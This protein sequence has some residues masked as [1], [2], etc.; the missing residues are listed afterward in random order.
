MHICEQRLRLQK[1]FWRQ[2]LQV[3][4]SVQLATV[5]PTQRSAQRDKYVKDQRAQEVRFATLSK[6][7][8][9]L[10]L[11]KPT[12]DAKWVWDDSCSQTACNAVS[13]QCVNNKNKLSFPFLQ[14]EPVICVLLLSNVSTMCVNQQLVHSMGNVPSD[15][16]ATQPTD[17]K[18][19]PFLQGMDF[20]NEH[21]QKSCTL[22]VGMVAAIFLMVRDVVGNKGEGASTEDSSEVVA[23][24]SGETQYRWLKKEGATPVVWWNFTWASVWRS[25]H[26]IPFSPAVTEL[27]FPCMGSG[28]WEKLSVRIPEGDRRH[29]A[30]CFSKVCA[31]Q[32]VCCRQRLRWIK[33]AHN[34]V[35]CFCSFSVFLIPG[36]GWIKS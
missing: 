26:I 20:W 17:V 11:Q 7:Q 4:Q 31:W 29:W 25:K 35:N 10:S 21:A 5:G 9:K 33:I 24:L 8:R 23:F 15:L 1:K 12:N 36:K 19:G 18:V 13:E 14:P 28:S 32:T 6:H 30:I 3:L 27:P 16:L 34:L 2:I 22:V